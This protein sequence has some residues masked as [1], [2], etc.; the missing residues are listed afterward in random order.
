MHGCGYHNNG[1][2]LLNFKPRLSA[3]L[4]T[5]CLSEAGIVLLQ[6]LVSRLKVKGL[7]VSST[8]LALNSSVFPLGILNSNF[9]YCSGCSDI[10]YY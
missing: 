4:I 2:T 10:I 9:S 7:A 3:M 6:V 5:L 8:N 1:A